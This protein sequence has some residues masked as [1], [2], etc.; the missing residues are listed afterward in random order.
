MPPLWIFTDQDRLPDPCAVL[1]GLP[2]GL[3][4]VVLRA[5]RGMDPALAA[6]VAR[7]CRQRRFALVVASDPALAFRLQAGR[8]MSRG[9]AVRRGGIGL[10][11]ASA[12]GPAELVRATRLRADA[13]FLSP[14]FATASHPGAVGLGVVRWA[15]MARRQTSPVL[16]LGGINAATARRLPRHCA[17]AGFVGAAGG[18]AFLGA[19]R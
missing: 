15:G 19:A 4:G 16:A 12:H 2:K 9:A 5:G 14:V 10:V 1:A 18:L 6:N 7:I 3:F 11:T 17:G 8:H 13:V